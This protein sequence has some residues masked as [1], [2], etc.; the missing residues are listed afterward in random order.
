MV[1]GI[2]TGRRPRDRA[3]ARHPPCRCPPRRHRRLG[4]QEGQPLRRGRHRSR[5][6]PRDRP[7]PGSCSA[8]AIRLARTAF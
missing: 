3:A 6:P 2:S 4:D 7:P 1:S 5:P 8:H